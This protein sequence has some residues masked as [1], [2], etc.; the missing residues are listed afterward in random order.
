[1]V[2]V[3]TANQLEDLRSL[4][5]SQRMTNLCLGVAYVTENGLKKILSSL[6]EAKNRKAIRFLVYLDGTITQPQAI[7]RLVELSTHANFDV[8]A[9]V[10]RRS[11][12][13]FHSKVY[14]AY[15]EDSITLLVGSHNL[16]ESA[17]KQNVEF[18][19]RLETGTHCVGPCSGRDEH[20]GCQAIRD[21]DGIWKNTRPLNH[22]SVC[23]YEKVYS[24]EL[25]RLNRGDDS[26]RN[27]LYSHLRELEAQETFEWPSKETA[28]FMGILCAGGTLE[29]NEKDNRIIRIVPRLKPG[30]YKDGRVVALGK[31]Y[32]VGYV[33]SSIRKALK[34]S[35]P[36]SL[37]DAPITD[38][39][40]LGI[41]IDC[42]REKTAFDRIVQVFG[43][44]SD[45]RNK[46]ATVRISSLPTGLLVKRPRVSVVEEFVKGYAY[47]SGMLSDNTGKRIW[48]NT[49]EEKLQQRLLAL[50]Q[51]I[52]IEAS[53][54]KGCISLLA[55]DFRT[56]GF[57]DPRD[58]I[59][60][61]IVEAQSD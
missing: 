43:H 19:L 4:I 15:S 25:G 33:F 20:V 31:Y 40:E 30:A 23:L 42:T 12:A 21:F 41:E 44:S 14:I 47:A 27:A 10:P 3:R 55:R 51:V 13:I 52:G 28:R 54:S 6:E 56:L 9:W 22:E 18:G 32:E 61:A 11:H 1:M 7:G 36:R 45:F 58:E 38:T 35:V 50:F 39:G 59:V 53:T 29:N 37:K 60:S 57:G 49:P 24:Y 5:S 17:L 48:L 34:D 26:A 2:K 46:C 16:T 8:R